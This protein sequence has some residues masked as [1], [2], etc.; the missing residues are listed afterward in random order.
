M[1]IIYKGIGTRKRGDGTIEYNSWCVIKIKLLW[2]I[3]L[4]FRY[5]SHMDL[6]LHQE[7][8]SWYTSEDYALYCLNKCISLEEKKELNKK[9]ISYEEKILFNE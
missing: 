2:L 8:R 9:I 3:T 7:L 6:H 1:N 4:K 5:Y